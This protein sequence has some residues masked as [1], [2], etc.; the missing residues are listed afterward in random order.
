MPQVKFSGSLPAGTTLYTHLFCPYAQRAYAA[1][2][3]YK[4]NEYDLHEVDLY[5]GSKPKPSVLVEGKVPVLAMSGA[6]FTESEDILDVIH[7]NCDSPPAMESSRRNEWKSIINDRLAPAGKA[8]VLSRN[9]DALHEVLGDMERKLV[10]QGTP[11]LASEEATISDCSAFPFIWRI[12]D[13]FGLR[14][15]PC[16][17]G[18]LARLDELESI[19]KTVNQPYWGWG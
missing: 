14:A 8:A 9:H 5:G 12:R 7:E 17:E 19:S 4:R 6:L 10:S 15:F 13:E 16:L 1:L 2:E 18:Y 11:F 3:L